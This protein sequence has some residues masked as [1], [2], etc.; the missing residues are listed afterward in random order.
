MKQ[1]VK[2]FLAEIEIDPETIMRRSQFIP[3]D[4]GG[5]GP[6]DVKEEMDWEDEEE[7][8]KPSSLAIELRDLWNDIW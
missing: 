4:P 7:K 1:Y 3:V 6:F 5:S 2:P 8:K